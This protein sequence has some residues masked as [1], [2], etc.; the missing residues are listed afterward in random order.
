MK[1]ILTESV[2]HLKIPS[3]KIHKEIFPEGEL[4]IRITENLRNK[5]VTIITNITPMNILEVLFTVDAARRTGAKIKQIIIPFLSYARQD[6]L[7]HAGEAVS[8]EVLCKL[9]KDLKI[10]IQVINIHSERLQKFR[11]RYTSVLPL[12]AKALPKKN[13]VIVSPDQGGA[14]RA[15]EI[16]KLLKAPMTI[17]KKIRTQNRITM[18][19]N[20]DCAGQSILIVEDMIS[21]GTTLTKA[22]ALLR[23]AKEIYCIS[24][25]GLFV[26]NAREKLKKTGIKKILVSN[27]LPVKPS[28]QIQ[29][30]RIEK[31]LNTKKT[32]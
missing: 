27:T 16:A 3:V 17:I 11:F 5:P 28:K 29:V 22:A 10:P 26:G 1:Y 25:H 18:T 30:I 13:W 15:G 23:N 9:L 32:S 14:E 6:K 12:L 31:V 24:A 7:Y 2:R 20:Q 8:G 19:F 21:T 4:Y